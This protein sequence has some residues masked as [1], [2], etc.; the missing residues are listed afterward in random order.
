LDGEVQRVDVGDW[1]AVDE[2]GTDSVEEDLKGAEEGLAE[3]GVEEEGLDCGWEISIEACD[4]EGFMMREVVG[5][6]LHR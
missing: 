4:A 3:E 2:H 1:G 6:I 5:L